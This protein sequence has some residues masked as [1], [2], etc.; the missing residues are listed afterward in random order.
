M[1]SSQVASRGCKHLSDAFRCLCLRKEWK[2]YSLENRA[3]KFEVPWTNSSLKQLLL[4]HGGPFPFK[5]RAGIDLLSYIQTFCHS[6]SQCHT[7]LNYPPKQPSSE[8]KSN[9]EE[10]EVIDPDHR[11]T[12]E[13]SNSHDSKKKKKD[14]SLIRDPD[15]TKF[16]TELLTSRLKQWNLLDE[17]MQVSERIN[18]FNGSQINIME[19]KEF[20]KKLTRVEKAA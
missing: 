9:S 8:R 7:D 13:E 18:V 4:Q 20:P 12:A 6:S 19:C 15:L 14:F 5:C 2:K 11:S 17:S 10:D 16:N 3:M 1:Y